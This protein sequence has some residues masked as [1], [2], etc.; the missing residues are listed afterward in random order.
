VTGLAT[1]L[2]GFLGL[3]L[4]TYALSELAFYPLDVGLSI[5]VGI[6]AYGLCGWAMVCALHLAGRLD[7]DGLWLGAGL[8]GFLIEGVVVA[9]LYTAPPLTIVWTPLAWHAVVTILGGVVWLGAGLARGVRPTLI[10]GGLLGIGLG[11]WGPYMWK[12]ESGGGAEEYAVQTGIAWLLLVTGHALWG[13]AAPRLPGLKL[14]IDACVIASIAMLYWAQA[15]GV[16]LFP[17]S[18]LLPMLLLA[19]FAALRGRARSPTPPASGT[20]GLLALGASVVLPVAAIATFSLTYG[21]P[22]WE[23]NILAFL[24]LG[25]PATFFWGRALLRGMR[26]YPD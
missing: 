22:E 4:V 1:R 14:R 3:G 6:L 12:A 9:E 19:T 10:R 25:L 26:P 2:A 11:L 23:A 20:P 8:F 15:W 13:R 5:W 17:V 16:S 7:R 18:M 24:G 21:L